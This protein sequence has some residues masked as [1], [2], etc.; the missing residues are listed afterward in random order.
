VNKNCWLFIVYKDQQAISAKVN[1]E[2]ICDSDDI[3]FETEGESGM[4]CS[5]WRYL[6][7][8]YITTHSATSTKP[9]QCYILLCY[10]Q[11][12]WGRESLGKYI[13]TIVNQKCIVNKQD[14]F[15]KE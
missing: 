6:N 14:Q 5:L 11:N 1:E 15:N 7:H 13:D 4:L 2:L 9:I 10:L 12:S 3:D 8:L